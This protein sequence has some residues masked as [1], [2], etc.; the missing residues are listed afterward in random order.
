MYA[1][2]HAICLFVSMLVY[3]M[4]CMH[5][6]CTYVYT[7]NMSEGSRTNVLSMRYQMCVCGCMYA[8][9]KAYAHTYMCIYAY[10]RI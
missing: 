3:T 4:G 2:M 9:T 10:I 5:V 8:Y 7:P 1:Y 6:H